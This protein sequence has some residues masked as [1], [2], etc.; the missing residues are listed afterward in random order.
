MY[1]NVWHA[2]PVYARFGVAGLEIGVLCWLVLRFPRT[3]LQCTLIFAN[4][5]LIQ[6][7]CFP[8]P[9]SNARNCLRL[10][11]RPD[12]IAVSS[13][14]SSVRYAFD[15]GCATNNGGAPEECVTST[16]AVGFTIYRLPNCATSPRGRFVSLRATTCPQCGCPL[17]TQQ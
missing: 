6:R 2:R 17:Q 8:T 7:R 4:R 9:T 10:D 12:T 13:S 15:P 14:V 1:T 11:W 5:T 16:T 3:S